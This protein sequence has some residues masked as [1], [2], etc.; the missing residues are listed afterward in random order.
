MT[1]GT[2][3]GQR[4]SGISV[5]RFVFYL[6]IGL[7]VLVLSAMGTV[8]ASH[9]VQK[10]RHAAMIEEA[11]LRDSACQANPEGSKDVEVA[12]AC[13]RAALLGRYGQT[14]IATDLKICET[15]SFQPE[16]CRK[17]AERAISLRVATDDL[18][19]GH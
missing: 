8:L 17:V 16:F 4:E 2:V 9:H 12:K 10:D 11:R 13:E 18:I 7:I 5:G 15:A 1:N 3:Q 6:W 14:A 19:K